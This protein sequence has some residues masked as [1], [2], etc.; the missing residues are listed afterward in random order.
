MALTDHPR[1][2]SAGL[3]LR[4]AGVLAA[5]DLAA[6][7]VFATI[8]RASH[9]EAAGLDAILQVVET[10]APF[11]VGWFLIAPFAGAFKAE[12]LHRPR[13]L[14]TRTALAWLLAAPI[15]VV[16]WSLLRQRPI[17]PTFVI[18]T[19]LTILIIL[20]GWRGLFAWLASRQGSL[21]DEK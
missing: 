20:L 10:A 6:F 7:L 9:G 18:I 17:Q 4:R 1:R 14:L 15:G 2:A 21:A 19:F 8:G 13:A 16:L 3:D 11:A 12:L 5:G